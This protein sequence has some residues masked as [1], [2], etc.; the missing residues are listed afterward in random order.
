M[1]EK[2]C[3]AR[4]LA[5]MLAAY[6]EKARKRGDLKNWFSGLS[7]DLNRAVETLTKGA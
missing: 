3:A 7:R 2:E 4:A 1:K 5:E 6:E